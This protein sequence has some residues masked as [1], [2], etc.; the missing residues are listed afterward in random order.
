MIQKLSISEG[1]V[2]IMDFTPRG[3]GNNGI[4]LPLLSPCSLASKG[5]NSARSIRAVTEEAISRG[6][7]MYLLQLVLDFQ[8]HFIPTS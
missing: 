1:V 5:E 2:K 6:H 7:R 3:R 8:Q 4:I